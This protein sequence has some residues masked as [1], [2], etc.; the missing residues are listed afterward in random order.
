[1][2]HVLVIHQDVVLQDH[3]IKTKFIVFP[4]TKNFTLLGI[5]FLQDAKLVLDIEGCWN[6]KDTPGNRFSL[7]Y[8]TSMSSPC[9]AP[10]ELSS[11]ENLRP[12]EGTI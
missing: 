6:F 9:T 7:H 8:E 5:D 3:T 12:E 1:M 11:L 2:E 10:V 4:N